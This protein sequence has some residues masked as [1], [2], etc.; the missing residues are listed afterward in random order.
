MFCSTHHDDVTETQPP[1]SSSCS[2]S[3][4][5]SQHPAL[6]GEDGFAQAS[7]KGK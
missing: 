3:P 5:P 6:L 2:K 7:L 1:Q 4:G